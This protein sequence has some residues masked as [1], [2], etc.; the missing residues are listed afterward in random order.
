MRNKLFISI[1]LILIGAACIAAAVLLGASKIEGCDT[2]M[3]RL[4]LIP[5]GVVILLAGIYEL[6][7]RILAGRKANGDAAAGTAIPPEREPPEYRKKRAMLTAPERGLYGLLRDFLSPAHFDILPQTA[8]INVIDKLTQTGYR[9]ELFRIADFCIADVKPSEPLLLIELN[10]ATHHRADR[11]ER[12]RRVQ[13]ICTRAGMPLIS[14]TLQE[15]ADEAHVKR[16]LKK[17]L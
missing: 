2:G 11:Q 14:F 10:D 17:H 3:P 8:L 6:A 1:V 15:A 4:I 5:L 9:N 16:T 12:D 13:E 7:R